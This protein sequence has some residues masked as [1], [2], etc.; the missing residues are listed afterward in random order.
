MRK[1]KVLATVTE[2]FNIFNDG[3]QHTNPAPQSYIL[4][5]VQSVAADL[6][7]VERI[8]LR[9]AVGYFSHRARELSKK[10]MPSEK[11]IIEQDGKT[12]VMDVLPAINCI[13]F[14]CD[15]QGNVTH[16]EEFLDND[17]GR[18]AYDLYKSGI[19]G[20]SWALGGSNGT[21]K[22]FSSVAKRFAGFDYVYNPNFIPTARQDAILAS[23]QEDVNELIMASVQEGQELPERIVEQGKMFLADVSEESFVS[24]L[25]LASVMEEN[26]SLT[27]ENQ[28]LA[29][30]ENERQTLLAS[31]LEKSPFFVTDEQKQAFINPTTEGAAETLEN[32]FASM[33]DT[34]FS[35][36]PSEFK[37]VAVTEPKVS[38]D[39]TVLMSGTKLRFG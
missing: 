6:K 1:F 31:V 29:A 2:T 23:V 35:Q 38:P 22:G 10:L 26:E 24:D 3:R 25:M 21:G 28:K 27:E 20:F 5:S 30:Q 16:T 4:K 14:S 33:N 9:E 37:E 13:H 34:D 39:D 32:L 7:T 18:K 17:E 12:V 15:D 19:G 36:F 8:K 11:E